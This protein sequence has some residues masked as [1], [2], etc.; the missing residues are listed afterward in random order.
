MYNGP[1]KHKETLRNSIRQ[2][3]FAIHEQWRKLAAGLGPSAAE[4][5]RE[6]E[7]AAQEMTV[8]SNSA[9]LRVRQL[10]EDDLTPEA[11]RQRLIAEALA[12]G[13]KKRDAA[14][15]RMRAAREVLA[16]KARAAAL[17]TLD[18]KREAAAREELC[19]L[20]SGTRDPVD[21]LLELAAGDDE[22]AGVAVSRYGESLLR[23]KGVHK[24]P[25][26]HRAVE[27]Q[28]VHAARQSADPKRQAA[29]AAYAALGEL[30]KGMGV[31]ESLADNALEDEGVEL[32]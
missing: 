19:L 24:A 15:A 21:V 10:R 22:L 29:A 6:Y 27:D 18:P 30:D 16:A 11:G 25:E 32:G 3:H 8:V 31:A 20:A 17:P 28:A 1:D 26:L 5:F 14:R 13:G 9:A 4:T 12:E 2:R 7:R 23:A